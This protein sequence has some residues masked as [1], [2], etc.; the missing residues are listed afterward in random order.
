[1]IKIFCGLESTKSIIAF[2]ILSLSS[3]TEIA[4][5]NFWQQTNGPSVGIVGTLAI[6]T[7]GHI[8]AGT[9]GGGVFRSTNNGNS[10]VSVNTGLTSTDVRSLV[11]NSS[12]AVFAG[13]ESDGVFRTTNN[14]DSW[15]KINTSLINKRVLSLAINSNGVIYAGT[16]R[17]GVFFST[18]NGVNW[19][20]SNAPLNDKSVSSIAV[21]SKGR[22]IAG[23]S[24]NGAFFSN[25]GGINWVQFNHPVLSNLFVLSIAFNAADDIFLGTSKG[26]LSSIDNGVSFT[27]FTI[28]DGLP[29]NFVQSLA[30]NSAGHIFA[31]TSNGISR[32][33][34]NGRSW[35]KVIS[36]LTNTDVLSLAI[37]NNGFIFAGTNGGGVF[38]SAQSTLFNRPPVLA[39]IAN[40][41]MTE[42]VTL[43]VPISATDPENEKI[44]FRAINLPTF[45]N[46]IDNS[47]NT[48]TILFTPGFDA[49]GVYPISVIA[50]DN[51]IPAQSDTA[52]FSLKINN[53]NRAP[54]VANA[55]ANQNLTVGGSSF[56]RDLNASPAVFIDLDGDALSYT[57][58]SSATNI[59][60]ANISSSTL[61]V[62]PVAPGNAT[63]TITANDGSGGTVSTTFMVTVTVAVNRPPVLLIAIP[64]QNLTVGGAP[65]IRDLNSAPQV[66]NDPDGDA[67]S[68]SIN[69][70]AASVATASV[71]ISTVTVTQRAAGSVTITVTANDNRGGTVSTNFT[72]T[73]NLP[74]YPSTLPLSTTVNYPSRSSASD[75]PATDYRIVGLP[76]ASNRL[77]NEFLSGT[78]NKDWQVYWDND[79]ASNFFVAF[80]GSANFQFSVG[81][82]F[83]IINRG[84][85]SI[86][87]PVPSAPL[88]AAQ[89]IELPLPNS[90]WNLITNPFTASIAWSK[91]QSA[92]N[93]TEPIYA[94]NGS[95]FT[96]TSFEPYFGYYFFNATNL[97]KLKIPYSAYFSSTPEANADPAIW[98]VKISFSSDES[99]DQLTSFGIANEASPNLDRFDFRKPRF[100]VNTPTVEF[101][102]PQWDANYSTFATDIRPKFEDAESWEFDVR[103]ISRQPAQLTFS[104]IKK[105]P[106][107][108]EVYLIDADHAQS[109]NLREDSLYHFTPA[110]ELMKF[111]VV[112]GRKVKV[113]EQ[114]SSL[115]LPKEF[116][117]E[118]NYP[119]P[120]S[121]TPRFAGNP[122]TTIPVAIPAATEIK[123]KIYNLLGAEVRTIYDASI[124]AGRYW[125]NWDGRNELGN[126]VA[127]GVYLYRLSTGKGVNLLGKMILIR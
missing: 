16:D 23:T 89:E 53:I 69:S 99:S 67:L 114:V 103:T 83:W 14:G 11:I 116:T 35:S 81:R 46:L 29:D 73:V 8:F 38:R 49:A 28:S 125:F 106:S 19:T 15:T 76:G 1:M 118:P 94:F 98:R 51:G 45:G 119:N 64:N 127:S 122:T 71:S 41:T 57:A 91:I 120:F 75:Y 68:Y 86:S 44:E 5:Q 12:G 37:N 18:D 111:K 74:A 52:F 112:V 101:K 126:Q 47:N 79:A 48:A 24:F 121:Q 33:T 87:T 61:T 93:V 117:L 7:S 55:I 39:L 32:S 9:I 58:S 72:V 59:A 66:F 21:N 110:A 30:I 54:F 70:S 22:I 63:I 84:A 82:A 27:Q 107:H 100:L 80:D 108:F 13:T 60:I 34:D 78:Q 123:L 42:G 109:V 62:A 56:N 2:L 65:F 6:N 10:W 85:L 50:T 113:Q 92:N 96:P 104:G 40:Q 105:I 26:G 31:G 20:Q 17:D 88:N 124:E 95:F 36:G 43:N 97:A 77:V 25:D 102:R 3:I 115:A 4:A 90:S